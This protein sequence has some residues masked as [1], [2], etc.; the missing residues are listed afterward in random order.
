MAKK[1][2]AIIGYGGM[3][4]WHGGFL[5]NSDVVNLMGIYDIKPSQCELAESRG[6]HAYSSLEE[7]LA[8]P[9]VDFVTIAVPNDQHKPLA[10]K[11][12]A[13]GKHVICEKPVTLSS[14]DLQEMI[15][16]SKAA[17]KLFTVHQNRRWDGEFLVMRDIYS[18]GE[19]GPVHHIESRCHGS[20]G[21]P[22]DWRQDPAQGGGMILDWGIHLIDQIMGIVTDK[23][24]KKIW[25]KCDHITNELVDDGFKLEMYFEGDLSVHVEVGTSNF[26]GLSRFYMI[27]R[28]GA[29]LIPDWGQPA[30]VVWCHN[31]NE[32]EVVPVVTAAGI[33]KTMA[34]RNEQSISEKSI[35]QPHADVHDYYRNWVRAIDGECEQC[36][37]HHQMMV[38]MLIMEA[39]FESDRTGMPVDVDLKF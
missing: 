24:L 25:C 10:L 26:I 38:D 31:Y 22:G 16:A 8:D 32:K 11:A 15:D 39:A 27:G 36:V 33:T 21:I 13:A 1:N 30:R 2:A 9:A 18:S 7:L 23:R 35:P 3:G 29:A 14:A 5:Q 4:G 28:D 20:R 19:L 6:I 17:G 12:L 34:P 37:T